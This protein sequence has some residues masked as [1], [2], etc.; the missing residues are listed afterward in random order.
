VENGDGHNDNDDASRGLTPIPLKTKKRKKQKNKPKATSAKGDNQSKKSF[1]R[2]WRASSPTT[3]AALVIAGI[4]AAAA[5]GYVGVNI[6]QVLETKWAMQPEHA[7]LIIISRPP[8]LLQPI[9]CNPR[10]ALRTGNMRTFVK[11]VG[12]ARGIKV[13][14]YMVTMKMVPEIKT[15]NG[16]LDLIPP[17]DCGAK[18]MTQE[19][20]LNLAPGQ[21][22]SVGIRGSTE[23]IPNLPEG[24]AFQIYFVQCVHYSD[25]Y[26]NDHATC[27][28]F[29]LSLPS[30][31]PLDTLE[32]SPSFFCDRTPHMGRF[33]GTITGHCQN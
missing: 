21:E 23:T 19:A 30:T 11:N 13:N 5:V 25:D 6:W 10:D 17:V 22:T 8:E 32:G 1:A 2:S 7:P 28:T 18:S 33:M 12:N 15:G 3:K 4:A 26:G 9:M 20:E 24:T 27:E 16:L 29:R 14:P 31:D